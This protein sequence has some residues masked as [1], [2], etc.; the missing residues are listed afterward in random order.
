M[1]DTFSKALCSIILLVVVN[2]S[3]IS[4]SRFMAEEKPV[5]A[6]DLAKEY[7]AS[8]AQ[9][10][11]KYQG[12]EVMVQGYTV[13]KP[14]PLSVSKGKTGLAILSE[15]DNKDNNEIWCE[16]DASDMAE[17]QKI[18]DKQNITVKGKLDVRE[19]GLPPYI[20]NCKLVKVQ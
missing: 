12:K 7:K 15:K 20:N 1:K 13:D 11:G 3:S 18:N 4:C 6:I 8:N 5:A 2:L 16:F 14:G 19:A 9:F 17:F 10:A